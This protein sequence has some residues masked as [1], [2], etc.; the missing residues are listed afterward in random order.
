MYEKNEMIDK[1]TFETLLPQKGALYR[2]RTE[3]NCAYRPSPRPIMMVVDVILWNR[4]A[5]EKGITWEW[6]IASKADFDT[7]YLVGEELKK[8]TLDLD[9]FLTYWERVFYVNNNNDSNNDGNN[10][11]FAEAR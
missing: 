2:V 4:G 3:A 6:H 9:Y 7:H 10:R 1:I 5:W 11:H 8:T